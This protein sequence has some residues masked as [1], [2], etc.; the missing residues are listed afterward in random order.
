MEVVEKNKD[1]PFPSTDVLWIVG[2]CEKKS[3]I[4]KK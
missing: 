1:G 3:E 4:E 2:V